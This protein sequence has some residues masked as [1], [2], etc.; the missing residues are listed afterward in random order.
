ME[1]QLADSSSRHPEGVVESL[2]VN[3]KGSYVFADFVVLDMQDD[4][5]MPLILGRPFLS[6]VKARIDVGAEKI[7][8]CIGKRNML[9][10]FQAKEEYCYLVQNDV[11]KP[12]GRSHN[13]SQSNL[14]LHQLNQ[15]KQRKCGGRLTRHYHPLLGNGMPNGINDREESYSSDFKW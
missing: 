10:R 8:F 11:E 5:G 7:R 13:P 4:G 9:F 3:V 12:G 15:R 14:R 1:V 2:L 6:D